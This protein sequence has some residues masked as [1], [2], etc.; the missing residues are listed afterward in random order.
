MSR[1]RIAFG[2][3][4]LVIC[5]LVPTSLSAQA[6]VHDRFN[7]ANSANLGID[8]VPQVGAA[9]I[10]NNQVQGNSPFQLG[11]STHATY[12]YSYAETVIRADWAMNGFGGDRVSIVAGVNANTW[13]GI[14]ARIGDNDGDGLADRVWFNL[15]INAGN[16]YGGSFFQNLTSP[17]PSGTATLY[18]TNNGD[19]AN[20]LIENAS[21]AFSQLISSSGILTN[22]PLGTDIAIGYFNDPMLDNVRAWVG[23]PTRPAYTMEP[24]R[25]GTSVSLWVTG[26]A[27]VAPAYFA[28]STAGAGPIP[29]TIGDVLLSFPITEILTLPTDSNGD[30]LVPLGI[31]PASLTGVTIH[32]QVLDLATPALSNGFTITGF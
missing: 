29:T 24:A 7:R 17:I 19:T 1:S 6:A 28:L 8:W 26:C 25:V 15:A 3:A 5:S 14:E 23:D 32:T 16:W 30:G 10:T 9:T 27:P 2:L 4:I 22:P 12:A 13:Q 11:W 31:F 20:L 18:F 21:L